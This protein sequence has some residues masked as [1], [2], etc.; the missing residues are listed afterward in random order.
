MEGEY[1]SR[2][3]PIPA[4]AMTHGGKF[5]ADDV[6]STALLRLLRPDI[7]VRRGFRVPEG[8]DGLVYDIGGGRFDHH[9][10]GAPVRE[11][12]TPYAAF[13]L[14]W[15]VY[16]VCAMERGLPPDRFPGAAEEEAARFDEKFIQPLDRDDNTGCGHALA[17]V[18]G[19]FNPAWDGEEPPDRCFE[20]AV[21]FA[22]VILQKRLEV[23]YASRRAKALVEEALARAEDGVV[24][25]E[26]FAPW[27]GGLIPSGA[28]FAV[29]PSQR[30]GWSAQGVPMENG[31]GALKC[32]FPEAWAGRTEQELPGLSGVADLTFCHNNRFLV[33]ARTKEGAVAA[34]RAAQKEQAGSGKGD[35]AG[36]E[37]P[38][39]E[40][41]A[42]R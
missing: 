2:L 6:F 7:R 32:P 38:E 27:K 35:G 13:G 29:Y 3:E 23:V 36:A 12:G 17:D 39:A 18:V 16:G 40:K 34:C 22:G 11:N 31:N 26:R 42:E 8:F 20:E 33:S 15:R 30:G 1:A 28:L 4:R 25:L 21:A 9:Q 41:A 24:V 37:N 19:S 10:K 5:H 14:L